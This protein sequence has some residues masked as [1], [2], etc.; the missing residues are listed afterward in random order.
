MDA[1]IAAALQTAKD[2]HRARALVRWPR[3]ERTEKL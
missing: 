1:T 2:F 3:A